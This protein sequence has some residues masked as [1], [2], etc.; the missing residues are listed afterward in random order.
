MQY[1]APGNQLFISFTANKAKRKH[2]D[3]SFTV[4]IRLLTIPIP[5]EDIVAI[6]EENTLTEIQ[7]EDQPFVTIKSTGKV[8]WMFLLPGFA[9]AIVVM[10]AFGLL[11]YWKSRLGK[12]TMS[13]SQ[14]NIEKKKKLEAVLK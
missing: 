5:E 11:I 8:D 2:P 10:I 9:I 6:E 7:D 1:K 12:R 13:K 4:R 3:P 14:Y